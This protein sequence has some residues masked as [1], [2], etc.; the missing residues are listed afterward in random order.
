QRASDPRPK[1]RPPRLAVRSTAAVHMTVAVRVPL[2]RVARL[3]PPRRRQC[4]VR[5][6]RVVAHVHVPE[7]ARAL[8]GERA[9]DR[10]LADAVRSAERYTERT[11]HVQAPPNGE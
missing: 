3:P 7:A 2:A 10:R 1:A 6:R 11:V 5:R 4:D 9:A 8:G